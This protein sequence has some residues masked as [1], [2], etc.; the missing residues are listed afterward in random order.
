M[1]KTPDEIINNA[2]LAPYD[3]ITADQS[4][5]I[6]Q[7]ILIYFGKLLNIFLLTTFYYF[8]IDIRQCENTKKLLSNNEEDLNPKSYEIGPDYAKGNKREVQFQEN[9]TTPINSRSKKAL[10]SCHNNV[11]SIGNK[12]EKNSTPSKSKYNKNHSFGN[13]R[14]QKVIIY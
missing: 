11:G 6:N 8:K 10:P 7:I 9:L 3:S 13:Q 12:T 5:Q 4:K 14:N 1:E 2:D